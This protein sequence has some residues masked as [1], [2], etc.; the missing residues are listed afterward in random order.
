MEGFG[1]KPKELTRIALM[2]AV[3]CILAPI[4]LPLPGSS[5]ALTMATFALYLM[6]FILPPKQTL[7]AVFL[8][9]LIGAAGLP[10]F[11]GFLSGISRFA[12]PGGGYLMGYLFLAGI[13]SWF[14]QKYNAPF[15]QIAGMLFGTIAM[16]SLGTVWLAHS[17]EIPFSAA[18]LTG[19]P[20][21]LPLDILK[22]SLSFYIGRKLQLHIKK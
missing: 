19:I 17:T 4:S 20:I 6:A 22:I 9:L 14:V 18:L 11:A 15:L 8:Y 16:Y 7:F 2:T 5:V 10:V 12:A 21:F 13:S 1:L 3:L